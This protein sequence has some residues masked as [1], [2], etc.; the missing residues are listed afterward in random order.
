M[1]KPVPMPIPIP[2][3]PNIFENS[4]VNGNRSI[5]NEIIFN[6]NTWYIA[7]DALTI[8]FNTKFNP[9]MENKALQYVNSAYQNQQLVYPV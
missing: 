6:T 3:W 8:P 9:K 5:Q 7:P 4:P 1:I 2:I